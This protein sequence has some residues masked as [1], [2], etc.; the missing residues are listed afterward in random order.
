MYN[1]CLCVHCT[2]AFVTLSLCLRKFYCCLS[3]EKRMFRCVNGWTWY[4]HLLASL[5]IVRYC[6]QTFFTLTYG[7]R[8]ISEATSKK[9]YVF[10]ICLCEWEWECAC[11]LCVRNHSYSIHNALWIRS[12]ACKSWQAENI[13]YTVDRAGKILSIRWMYICTYDRELKWR[14]QQMWASVS[15]AL[16]LTLGFWSPVFFFFCIKYKHINIQN[17]V[18]LWLRN[19]RS[20]SFLFVTAGNSHSCLRNINANVSYKYFGLWLH[21]VVHTKQ[22]R[23]WFFAHT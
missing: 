13:R 22:C 6:R 8:R 3:I 12:A 23:T 19:V 21:S 11:T 7:R 20:V 1:K 5:Y 17:N 4:V 9:V 16:C 14:N 18:A 2:R 10:F 15:L